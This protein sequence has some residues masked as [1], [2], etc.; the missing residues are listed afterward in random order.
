M[1]Y[2]FFFRLRLRYVLSF[3]TAE[4]N[5]STTIRLGLNLL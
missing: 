4:S 3:A 1:M 5:I 2:L